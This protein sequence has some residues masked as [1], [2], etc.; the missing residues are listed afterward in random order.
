[1]IGRRFRHRGR[2]TCEHRGQ[3]EEQQAPWC[4]PLP[5]FMKHA[6]PM[7]HYCL[8][9]QFNESQVT[10]SSSI[11]RKSFL[12]ATEIYRAAVNLM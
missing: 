2:C 7:F 8:P 9:E 5:L 12:K 4:A 10:N 11:W 6:A 3:T 1:M